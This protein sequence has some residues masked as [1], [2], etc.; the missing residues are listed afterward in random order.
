VSWHHYGPRAHKQELLVLEIAR[1]TVMG[2]F[3]RWLRTEIGT[4]YAFLK[5]KESNTPRPE[6]AIVSAL[7]NAG[8]DPA[9][10]LSKLIDSF[11]F[12]A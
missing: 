5:G 9:F 4:G 12:R 1:T 11:S 10:D 2:R 3:S 6:V 8:A 7:V